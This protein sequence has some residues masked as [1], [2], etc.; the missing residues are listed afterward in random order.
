MKV[1]IL[2]DNDFADLARSI[3]L[4][5]RERAQDAGQPWD[6]SFTAD[7]PRG[8]SIYDQFR[9]TWYEMCQWARSHEINLSQAMNR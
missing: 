2:K 5:Y 1:Y 9:S 4:H 8:K 6:T 3:E 7:D